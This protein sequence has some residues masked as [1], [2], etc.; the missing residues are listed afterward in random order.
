MRY[1]KVRMMPSGYGIVTGRAAGSLPFGVLLLAGSALALPVESAHAQENSTRK[2][3][4]QQ[5]VNVPEIIVSA[6]RRD[7]A[8]TNVPASITAYSSDF[9]EKQNI[10]TFTDYA[11]KVPNL[12][13]QYGQ[14]GNLLWS[15]DRQTTIRG[16]V[17]NDT[18]AY[19]INDTPVPASV[20]P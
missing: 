10:Q 9:L 4:Y 2:G 15:G 3:E 5:T 20:S 13:F 11:T 6:R 17:G 1:S 14:G 16:V 18:T 19:Y 8:L 12:S 7:E